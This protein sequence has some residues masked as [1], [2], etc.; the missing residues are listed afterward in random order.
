MSVWVLSSPLLNFSLTELDRLASVVE[1]RLEENTI[2]GRR[3]V[4]VFT[5]CGTSGR[6]AW[7]C[8]CAF[9]ALFHRHFPA[10]P[11]PF[12][13]RISGGDQSLIVSNELPED[14]PVA[15]REDLRA[16]EEAA[17]SVFLVGIT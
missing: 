3:N 10:L 17:D 8:A 5:G 6:I 11:G 7:L 1:K 12:H 13:F 16:I 4:F 9:N 15:G 14:D 2:A